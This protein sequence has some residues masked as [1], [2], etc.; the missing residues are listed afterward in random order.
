MVDRFYIFP[1]NLIQACHSLVAH[2]P[3]H[4]LVI[5]FVTITPD[6]A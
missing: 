2:L 3:I 5:V 1:A 6:F 4:P